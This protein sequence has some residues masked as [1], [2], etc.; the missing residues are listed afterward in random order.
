MDTTS[1]RKGIQISSYVYSRRSSAP[2]KMPRNE[3]V[4]KYFCIAFI[5]LYYWKFSVQPVSK[6]THTPIYYVVFYVFGKPNFEYNIPTSVRFC[7][8]PV[9]LAVSPPMSENLLTNH[10]GAVAYLCEHTKHSM[11]VEVQISVNMT[12]NIIV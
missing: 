11:Y 1:G 5:R 6:D 4:T 2:C 7:S 9:K 12:H 3:M 8:P 10:S